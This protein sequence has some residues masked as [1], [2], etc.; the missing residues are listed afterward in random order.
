[1]GAYFNKKAYTDP[2]LRKEYTNKG[3]WVNIR[4]IRYADVLLM[5]AESANEKVFRVKQ[6]TIW[7]KYAHAPEAPIPIYYL[8]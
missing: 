4:L 7:N 2:A 6:S 5:G 3:F 8:K 1:M